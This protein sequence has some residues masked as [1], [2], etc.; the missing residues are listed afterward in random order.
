MGWSE[1][2]IPGCPEGLYPN[3]LETSSNGSG[4]QHS[5]ER[6]EELSLGGMDKFSVAIA[7]VG[8]PAEKKKPRA[9]AYVS[10]LL[11]NSSTDAAAAAWDPVDTRILVRFLVYSFVLSK[12]KTFCQFKHTVGGRLHPE[13]AICEGDFMVHDVWEKSVCDYKYSK[14]PRRINQE[15]RALQ[16]WIS[17]L[18]CAWLCHIA[19][20]STASPS[21]GR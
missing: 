19:K 18:S 5:Y 1:P 4:F 17:E 11:D 14:A 8:P 15:F 21:I 16:T 3:L 2:E 13:A 9:K 20:G 7:Q 12:H 10:P 6:T